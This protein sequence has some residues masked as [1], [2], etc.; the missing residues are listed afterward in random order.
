MKSRIE[1]DIY[2]GVGLDLL[3]LDNEADYDAFLKIVS[4]SDDRYQ[5]ENDALKATF[6]GLCKSNAMP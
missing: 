5:Y 3:K 1:K 6:T 4:L 2:K